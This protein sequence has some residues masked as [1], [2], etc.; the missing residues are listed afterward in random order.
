[1]AWVSSSIPDQTGRVVV[2]TGANS[3]IGL[4]AAKVLSRKGAH[5]VMA[6]RNV[7]KGVAAQRAVGGSSEVRKLDLADLASVHAFADDLEGDVDVL[8]DNGGVMA[9]PLQRTVDGFESQLGTNVMGHAALTA[10]LLPR[11]TD[12]VVWLSSAMHRFGH[13][14]LA[15][16][17]W[18]HR[19]YRRW[20]AYGQS[21]LADLMLAYELQRRLT[22]AGSSVRSVAAHPGYSSTNLQRNMGG[23]FTAPLQNL[24]ARAGFLVQTAEAGA[25]P[26]LYAATTP[27]LVGG[28]YVGPS[29]P[30]EMTGAPHLVGSSDASHDAAVGRAL[31]DQVEELAG[32]SFGL[33]A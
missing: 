19:R 6:C 22:L 1:M 11:V 15:D 16:L 20:P 23:R 3:G 31:F 29:G 30:G 13:I 14:D 17:N 9:P 27:D 8:V 2:I 10:L 12:R 4:E 7:D 18:E 21:K 28:S 5:V 33:P 25:W 32:V 24:V 26:T